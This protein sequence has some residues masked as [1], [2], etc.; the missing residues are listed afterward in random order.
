MPHL[1]KLQVLPTNAIPVKKWANLDDAFVDVAKEIR[2]TVKELLIEQFKDENFH[3]Y[4]KKRCI[5]ALTAYEQ[6]IEIDPLNA[7]AYSNK[8]AALYALN[9]YS[10]A[11]MAYEEA[12]Q[13]D[14][15]N[16]LLQQ[17]KGKT[18]Y[19]L[20]HYEEALA[21]FNEAI[22]INPNLAEVHRDKA[23]I[24]EALAIQAHI[25]ANEIENLQDNAHTPLPNTERNGNSIR[26][27]EMISSGK[28]H[29]GELVYV[30]KHPDQPAKIV[31]RR[32]V[33]FQGKRTSINEWGKKIA[34]WPSINIYNSVYLERT[35]QP[36]GKL[37]EEM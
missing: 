21:A 34:G 11:L 26:L 18:L 6:A 25:K 23:L 27:G 16:S 19:K 17:G 36:L 35:K 2:K 15:E 30:D 20:H 13:L 3:D 28:V 10:E 9:R 22:H 4:L 33:E 24:L 29:A 12:E 7:L 8:G 1:A 37:R 14:A 32:T 31:D 5:E